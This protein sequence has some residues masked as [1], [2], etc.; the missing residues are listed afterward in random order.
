MW[1]KQSKDETLDETKHSLLDSYNFNDLSD[2]QK[3][4]LLRSSTI[5]VRPDELS[6]DNG[7]KAEKMKESDKASIFGSAMNIANTIM[8][9][10]V[11]SLSN[12]IR[13]FGI[14]LGSFIIAFS[15]VL[16]YFSC[17]LLLKTKN[18][19]HHSQYI[20]IGKHCFGNKGFW[21][22]KLMIVVSNLGLCIA[23]LIIF[24]T[25][26]KNLLAHNL[27]ANKALFYCHTNFFTIAAGVVVLPFMFAKSMA[28]LQNLSIV[29]VIAAGVFCFIIIYHYVQTLINGTYAK[30]SSINFLPAIQ[31]PVEMWKALASVTSVFTA[32]VFQV[33]FFSVYK[34]LRNPTDSRMKD[35]TFLGLGVVLTIYLSVAICGY[36]AFGSGSEE[37]MKHFTEK[38]LGFIPY[39]TINVAFLFSAVLTLP[40]A[41]FGARN[42]VYGA[43]KLLRKM[44]GGRNSKLD[45]DERILEERYGLTGAS[46]VIFVLVLFSSVI[47]IAIAVPGINEV[48]SFLGST[49][50]NGISF[51][52]PSMFYLKL[53]SSRGRLRKTAYFTFTIGAVA[54]IVGIVASALAP[55]NY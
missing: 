10:G 29:A 23:Y 53:S 40:L 44:C 33:N 8:G 2:M 19:S 22:V 49:A 34:T 27:C 41:F 52:L 16:T 12:V 45:D 11:L 35:T 50:A 31:S 1:A 55:K 18:L 42:E 30:F 39:V 6:D 36:L 47:A 48:L 26:T 24:S 51:L 7:E 28:K 5:E 21:F 43:V 9:A 37:L 4:R 13:Q 38:R 3:E 15:C 54:G 17:S 20:S 32:Y 14:L 25:V 46:Y